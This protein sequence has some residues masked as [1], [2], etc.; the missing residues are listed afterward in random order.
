MPLFF[1]ELSHLVLSLLVGF[2]I[3][4]KWHKHI[5]VFIT[6]LLGGVFIDLDHLI[7]YI[8]AFGTKFNLIFFLKGYQFLKTD[9]IYV[10]LHSWELVIILLLT[11]IFLLSNLKTRKGNLSFRAKG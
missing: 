2:V 3:W 8:L 11:S 4:K 5:G 10:P 7:D 1:H 9:K 6:A